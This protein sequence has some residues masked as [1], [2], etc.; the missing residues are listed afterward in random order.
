MPNF[1]T[2][3][4]DIVFQFENLDLKEIAAIME[5]DYK[6]AEIYNY[7]PV[8]YQDAIDNYRKVLEIVGDLAGNIIAPNAPSVDEEGAVFR[9]GKVT[10]AKGTRE[11]LEKL[12]QAELMGFTLPRRYDGLNC[13]TTIYVMAIEI[14]S[15]ADASLMNIFGLQDIAETINK[16]GDADQKAEFLPKFSSGKYTGAMA[17]TEPDAGSDLQAVKLH[18][19]Q[20]EKGQWRLR[21]MKRFIT[22]GCGDIHLVLARSEAGTKD[23]RGLSMFASYHDDTVQVRRIENK[24]GIHGSPTCEL[25][26]K[27]TPA[28]L[29]GKRKFG[30]IKYVMDLMNG[31]RIGVSAQA[32][33]IAQAA[34]EEAVKYARERE[35]F[36]KAIYTIPVVTNMLIDMRVR[37]ESNRSLMYATSQ[38]VDLRDKLEEK[39]NHIKEEGKDPG[40]LPNRQKEAAKISALLTPMTK[41]IL[42]ED[43]NKITYDSLQIHGGVGYMKEFNVERLVRDARITNIYEGTSQLQIVA[44]I[45]GVLND[46][47]A[48]HFEAKEK[49]KYKGTL[50]RLADQL[51]QIR[52]IFLD[53]LKYVVD[54]NDKYFQDVAAKELVELYSYIFTGYL[55]LD[56][57]EKESRKVF[58][59]NRYIITAMANARRNAEAIKN[60]QFSDL[61]H[62]DEILI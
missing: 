56:E 20:D 62:A 41:Y 43:A 35:Q 14:V 57:A 28:Q 19:Y 3:N 13:P 26:F 27:D 44:A 15:R 12:G 36:G 53:S 10:Y 52:Q 47:L 6:Q 25:Q 58:I 60:E 40:D 7:A 38:W 51:K 50:E 37:L 9:D 22:N 55:L 42:A 5:D 17:L 49:K 24:L 2:D 61:L 4:K 59:A 23:G 18:A 11:A 48:N 34:Y 29:I 33:G 39:V 21:G 16:F 8:D 46:I 1:F 32:L 45:G 54:K 30:L 31:A